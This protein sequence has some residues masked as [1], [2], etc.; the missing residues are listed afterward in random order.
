[1]SMWRKG[2]KAREPLGQ[3][4]GPLSAPIRSEAIIKVFES[5]FDSETSQTAPDWIG[6]FKGPTVTRASRDSLTLG[7]ASS[8]LAHL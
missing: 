3:T 2:Q 4:L 5:D 8:P 6:A 1:M 7:F